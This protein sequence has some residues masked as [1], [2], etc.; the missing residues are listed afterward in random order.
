MTE[1]DKFRDFLNRQKWI[2]AK[3]YAKK[4]PHHY[5]VKTKLSEEDQEIFTE[6][7]IYIRKHGVKRPFWDMVFTYFNLDG[8]DYWT[9]GD[10]IPLTI[11]LNRV[12]NCQKK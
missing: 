5:I 3:T 8:Y 11:I 4:A 12:G 1:I 6:F 10:P 2:F 7:A 9:Y